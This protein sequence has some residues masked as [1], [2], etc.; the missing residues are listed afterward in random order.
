MMLSVLFHM[1]KFKVCLIY[2]VFLFPL[3]SLPRSIETLMNKL[4]KKV[5]KTYAHTNL[6]MRNIL[7]N[8]FSFFI[9]FSNYLNK[10]YAFFKV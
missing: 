2:P 4:N 1:I 6:N 9:L 10:L 8:Y 3:D 5:I 7:S